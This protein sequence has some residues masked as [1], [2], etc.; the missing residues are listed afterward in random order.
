MS[1]F[2]AHFD[3]KYFYTVLRKMI[4]FK[5]WN[6]FLDPYLVCNASR[7]SDSKPFPNFVQHSD[8]LTVLLIWY[9]MAERSI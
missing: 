4:G 2:V 1:V 5:I 7:M 3:G 9:Y 6:W 8:S